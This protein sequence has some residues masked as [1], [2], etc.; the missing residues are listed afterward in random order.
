[1]TSLLNV[2]PLHEPPFQASSSP[3]PKIGI[4]PIAVRHFQCLS[5]CRCIN[6]YQWIVKATWQSTWVY[7][8]WHSITSKERSYINWG[9]YTVGRRYE[10]YV[11][12]TGSFL[13]YFGIF[14]IFRAPKWTILCRLQR[15]FLNFFI[16]RHLSTG[17]WQSLA[18]VQCNG[19][20]WRHRYPQ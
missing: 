17:V 14:G 2:T 16:A 6:E 1:M 7:L 18:A 9:Y 8:R 19:A 10:F 15:F 12:V 5:P 13:V 3:L 20:K 11:R 4:W